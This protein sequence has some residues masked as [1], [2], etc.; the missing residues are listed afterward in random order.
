MSVCFTSGAG[1]AFGTAQ[2]FVG[3]NSLGTTG[4]APGAGLAGLELI[5][6]SLSDS[7]EGDALS[8][9][10]QSIDIYSNSWG[11]SDDGETLKFSFTA[12]SM[13]T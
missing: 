10:Q 7:R 2:N 4:A 3:G 9:E 6:C 1:N 5:S 11:P 8:H 13:S 12:C